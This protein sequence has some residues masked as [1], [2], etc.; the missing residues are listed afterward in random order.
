MGCILVDDSES[1]LNLIR[2][3]AVSFL[4]MVVA[5]GQLPARLHFASC[6]QL[7]S[8]E[9]K[10]DG[11][12]ST[13]SVATSSRAYRCHCH[14]PKP[15]TTKA[16]ASDFRSEHEPAEHEP[17]NH[18]AD[19]CLICQSLLIPALL[20]GFVILIVAEQDSVEGISYSASIVDAQPSTSIPAP[21]G[22]PSQRAFSA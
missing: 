4:C 17:S 16:S 14:L 9:C 12:R 2:P 6:H 20:A 10:A 8:G 1:M 15:V 19:D 13:L 7:P 3:I 21:R 22:P 11:S 5:C 18:D